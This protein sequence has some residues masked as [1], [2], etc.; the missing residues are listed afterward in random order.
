MTNSNSTIQRALNL[1]HSDARAVLSDRIELLKGL[2]G[3]NLFIT[4]GTGFLG[5]WIMELIR[6]LN[7]DYE[8]NTNITVYGRNC[9]KFVC[10]W[11][12]LANLSWVRFQEG[13]IRYLVDIPKETNY[14]IHAAALQDRRLYNSQPTIVAETNSIGTARVLKACL[15]LESLEKFLLLSSC[16]VYGTQSWDIDSIRE[17]YAGPLRCDQVKSVYPESKRMAEIFVHSALSESKLPLVVVRPFAFVGPYQSMQLPWAVTEFIRDSS[18]GGPIRIMGDGLT[19]RSILYASDFA[20]TVLAGL[21][22]GK[23]GATYNIGSPEPV[24]LLKL[25][26]LITQ[27]F[28]PVPEILTRV[29]QVGLERNRLVPNMDLATAEI[30]FRMTVPLIAA[31]QKTIDWHGLVDF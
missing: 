30:G 6:V 27:F 18:K 17:D 4:G 2:R 21:V 1:V 31:L 20:F 9:Q 16:L 10:R 13:D 15:L 22:Q 23:A 3:K 8:F 29:G 24:E 11:P 7:E 26:S 28:K 25:A 19:V 14:V 5:T 12:H